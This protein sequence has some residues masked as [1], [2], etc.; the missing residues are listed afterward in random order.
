MLV[1]YGDLKILLLVALA[2]GM[3]VAASTSLIV[4]GANFKEVSG[5]SIMY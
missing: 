2:S 3:M 4:E 5:N 1:H